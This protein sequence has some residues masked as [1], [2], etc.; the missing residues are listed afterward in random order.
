MN[1]KVLILGANG[2]LGHSLQKVFPDAVCRGHEL[3]ITNEK[4]IISF[5]SEL[6]PD[7]VINAAAYTDVDGC[8]DNQDIA[9]AVNG[10]APG[11]IACA[12]KK[13]GAVLVHYSTDYVF[14]G[15]KP[16]Y[17]ESDAVNPINAYGE[18]KLLG[19]RR[20]M[21]NMDNYRII[22][23]SWLFGRYG[24]NFVDTVL[25]LSQ[26]MEK[27]RVVDDQTG[28][29]TY[30][31]DLAKK[32]SELINLDSGIYHITNDG[33]CSWFEF[34]SAFINNAVPCSSA[35]FP[36]KAKRPEFSVLKNTKTTPMRHWKDALNDYLNGDKQ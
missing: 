2:M 13:I 32:T 26:K 20:I 16:E 3:D 6:K 23:T 36:R 22:R 24:K 28:K 29:P 4:D 30:T 12:C 31:F 34:A 9:F 21:E 11:Y 17:A 18:S 7:I 14:D 33:Q 15:A 27:V 25:S 5:I 19:E 1:K 10:E 35:E 8:E